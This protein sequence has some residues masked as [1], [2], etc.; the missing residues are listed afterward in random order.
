[1]S[2]GPSL[3]ERAMPLRLR[4]TIAHMRKVR[5]RK[6]KVERTMRRGRRTRRASEGELSGMRVSRED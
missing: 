1:M 5:R 4:T 6:R 3:S 2:T